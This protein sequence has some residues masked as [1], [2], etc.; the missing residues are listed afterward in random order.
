MNVTQYPSDSSYTTDILISNV[1]ILAHF[2]N[3][4]FSLNYWIQQ[5]NGIQHASVSPEGNAN[6]LV[7]IS[8]DVISNT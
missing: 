6:S 3:K 4:I 2:D 5:V 8:F 1:S 7:T